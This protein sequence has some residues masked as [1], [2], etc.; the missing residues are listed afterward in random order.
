VRYGK[1]TEYQA[2]GVIHYH[3]VFRL[4]VAPPAHEPDHVAPPPPG[5]TGEL[6]ATAIRTATAAAVVP[7]PVGPVRWG[8]QLDIRPIRTITKDEDQDVLSPE[9]V[10]GYIAKYVT[11]GAETLGPGLNRRLT[12]RSVAYLPRLGLRPHVLALVQ[13]AWRLGD[14]RVQPA[15]SRL[16]LRQWAH[17]LGYG[18]HWTTRSR[19]YATTLTALR[20]ARAEHTRRARWPDGIALDAWGRPETDQAVLVLAE[21]SFQGAGRITSRQHVLAVQAATHA[22][23]QRTAC[24][25]RAA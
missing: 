19:R 3:A 11:K 4:D 10:A 12:D 23:N 16:R 17:Q 5:W 7:S 18:G 14:E 8:D 13:A 15:L 22:R 25:E 6:L 1:V 21:W 9:Q 2:R 24:P 20:T